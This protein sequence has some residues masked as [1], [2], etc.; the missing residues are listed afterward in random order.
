MHRKHKKNALDSI[1]SEE[2]KV[3]LNKYAS[4]SNIVSKF[5]YYLKAEDINIGVFCHGDYRTQNVLMR[6]KVTPK[7]V[8]SYN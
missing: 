4:I 2:A 5:E 1:K 7:L 8:Y 3:K 6:E